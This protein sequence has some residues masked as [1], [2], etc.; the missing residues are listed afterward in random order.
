MCV[1]CD[2]RAGGLRGLCLWVLAALHRALYKHYHLSAG[3]KVA[4][5]F[6]RRCDQHAG[7]F[8]VW[9]MGLRVAL[10]A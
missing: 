8:K 2:K 5:F 3:Q 6:E 4:E 1:G 10:V 7:G 9:E